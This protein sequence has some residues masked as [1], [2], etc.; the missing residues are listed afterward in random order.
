[1]ANI[2][3]IKTLSGTTYDIK[4][5]VSGYTTN[6]GTI[7]GIKMNGSSKGTSGVVDLGTVITA[8]QDISGK[9]DKADLAAVATSG[10]Y[11]DLSNKPTIPAAVAVKGNNETSYRTGNVN[12]TAAN[13]G[14]AA[15]SHTHGNIQNGG[16]LQTNDITIASGDKLVVTDSSDSNKIARTSISFDGSTTTQFLSKKGTWQTVAAGNVSHNDDASAG[17][18]VTLN[19]DQ[20]QGYSLNQL[21]KLIY[22]V[23]AIYQTTKSTFSPSA[24]ITGTTWTLRL[25]YMYEEGNT[26]TTIYIWERTA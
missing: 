23:G 3:K 8:H 14:A 6:T 4:D 17:S 5:S 2:S 15:S 11:N 26:T 16:T 1:M 7:T 13:I 20:L 12:L 10:S 25:Q 9:A 22:P 18:A 19:A 24:L 21:L